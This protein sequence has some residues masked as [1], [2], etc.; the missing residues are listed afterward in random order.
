MVNAKGYAE[1]IRKGRPHY[2]E[3]K[4]FVFVGGARNEKRNLSYERM[5]NKDEIRSFAEE[6]ARE[7]GYILADYHE[8]SKVAL[9]CA[10]N[11]AVKKRMIL[12]EK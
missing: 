7:S 2:V 9:L 12:F 1:L 6:I 11:D 5:P 8:S 3:V 4:G 10:D